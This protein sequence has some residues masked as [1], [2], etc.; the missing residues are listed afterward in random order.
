MI[1]P[2]YGG[3]SPQDQDSAVKPPPEGRRKVV[4]STDIAESSLTIDGVRVVIDTGYTRIAEYDPVSATQTL[5]TRRASLANIDQRRGRAGRV[6][7]GVCYR[8][9]TEPSTKGLLPQPVPEI[10]NSDLKD[11]LLTLSEWGVDDPAKLSWID[12]PP[13]GRIASARDYLINSG[14][15]QKNGCLTEFGKRI[16]YY[17]LSVDMA[18]LIEKQNTEEDKSLAAEIA[19]V[20]SEQGLGGQRTDLREKIQF[21]RKE[22][23]PRARI[24]KSQAQKWAGKTSLPTDS[25]GRIL[26]SAWPDRLAK[27]RG[28]APGQFL[29]ASGRA[30]YLDPDDLLAH[31]E[32]LVTGGLTGSARNLRM[33][34]AAPITEREA[35]QY[36][37]VEEIDHAVLDISSGKLKAFREKRIGAIALSKTQMPPP[38]IVLAQQAFLDALKENGLT[39]LPQLEIVRETQIRARYSTNDEVVDLL[40]SNLISRAEEWWLPVLGN[41]PRLDRPSPSQLRHHLMALLDW[42]VSQGIQTHCPLEWTAPSGRHIPINYLTEGGPRIEVRVQEVYGLNEHPCIGKNRV[43]LLISLTSPARRSVA[44]TKD[45]S[46]FWRAGYRDM[47]KDMRAR[48]PKHDWPEDPANALPHEGRTK[49]NLKKNL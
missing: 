21:F 41:P 5:Q 25:I 27:R 3:L 48:Y 14:I 43:P 39:V 40:D 4:L 22:T 28:S 9:W 36:G 31:E 6:T 26:L 12:P 20:L 32:W 38:D 45:L 18:I 49:A 33:T 13:V 15:I 47:A 2:L 42:S 11:L 46:A 24:L 16:S 7:A 1:A 37:Q 23:T 44:L 19:V 34:S 10:L 17:P 29:L 35:M 30:A 8:L